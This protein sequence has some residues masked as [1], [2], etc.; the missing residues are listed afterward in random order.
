MANVFKKLILSDKPT[1]YFLC[2]YYTAEEKIGYFILH[3]TKKAKESIKLAS[4]LIQIGS[5]HMNI[6][7]INLYFIGKYEPIYF[8]PKIP[9]DYL[10]QGEI[11]LEE[12]M[13]REYFYIHPFN[14]SKNFPVIPTEAIFYQVRAKSVCVESICYPNPH[15]SSRLISMPI[16]FND[17]FIFHEN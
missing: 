1:G 4:E 15:V 12:E 16:P 5:A 11:S 13:E 9:I 6:S 10:I 7:S 14:I 17:F 3:P 8:I 2:R